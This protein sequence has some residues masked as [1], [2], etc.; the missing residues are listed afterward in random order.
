M[1]DRTIVK[2]N[3][4]QALS[5][6]RYWTAYAVC[7]VASLITGLFSIVDGFFETRP[8]VSFPWIDPSYENTVYAEQEA[9]RWQLFW[10][11]DLLLMIFIA[12]P[13]SVG[14]ARFF[15]RNRFGE[16][17]LPTMFSC[18]HNNYGSTLGGMFTTVLITILWTFL[19]VVPGIVKGLEYSMVP[20][21]LS[22]NPSLP[23]ERAREISRAMTDGE[24]GSIFVFVLSFL[25]W[26]ILAGIAAAMISWFFWPVNVL[27]SIVTVSFVTA[28][29][30][31]SFAE[32][33][34]FM[35]DRAIRSGAVQA[36]EL[37]LVSGLN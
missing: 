33:Y 14:I 15:V 17:R 35:R 9:A 31:A 1:W 28:Y 10:F 20:F 12:L 22:D 5:G 19:F 4:K 32:L 7:V 16:T 26:L 11:P 21:I 2:D 24:K 18:F 25:G 27:A 3:A 13:L 8:V 37:G 6:G 29:M 36:A 34:V 23:G 30:Q